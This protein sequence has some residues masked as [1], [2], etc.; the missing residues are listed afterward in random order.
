MN[1]FDFYI[2]G[3]WVRSLGT[4]TVDVINPATEKAVAEISLGDSVDVDRAVTAARKAFR[5]YSQTPV[6]ERVDLLTTIREIYK[7]RLDDVADAIQSEMGAPSHLAKG[8]QAMVGLAHLK[9]AIRAL[10]N[11][12]FEYMHG[13]FLI[14]HEPIGVCGLITPWN[15]PVN[16]VVSKLAPCVAS[17]CTAV[18]KPSEIA[19]LS[20]LVIA[21]IMD[22]AKVPAGVF[23]LINGMGPVVGEAMSAHPDIDMMSFTGSTR[24]GVAVAKASADS[25]K[26]VSQELGG[27]SANIIL[28]DDA[29]ER[30]ISKGVNLCMNN[31]GQSCN[32]PTRMLI[33]SSRKSEA[34][35]IARKTAEQV[36]VGDPKEESTV[37]GPLVS[38]SQ[39]E[40]VQSL[41]ETGLE[42]GATLVT[43][44]AG[45][46]DGLN[47]GYYV[48]PTVFGDVKN[49]MTIAREEIFGPVL[50]MITYDDIDD[51]VAIAN[52]TDY[53]LAAYVSG[54]NK[55]TLTAI[56]RQ[57][58]AGQVHINYGSGGA[59]APF[60][61]YK[62]SGN[63]REKAEWGLE[64]FL[65]VKAIM[66]A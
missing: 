55:D 65:E 41:I 11:Y 66:G 3:Q 54:Q 45:K 4:E 14:R 46:P 20:S 13:D 17:G 23:N 15:W 33:P 9:A 63:G 51:A 27:K 38:A 58:R 61:G 40:K 53:G 24:G 16:Q 30:S 64:E 2:N 32:A 39:Y 12:E 43:G 18:L 1:K 8:P 6:A 50:S 60:G 28:D 62:Q 52:D 21:E 47:R 35:Q 29:F 19:P 22:E 42:E 49:D 10:N 56:G 34:F 5:S 59:D 31:T 37:V 25:V 26:R 57:L 36:V 7:R 44:G 48:K